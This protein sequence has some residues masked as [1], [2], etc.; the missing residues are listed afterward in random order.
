[1]NAFQP[2]PGG[3]FSD[4]FV[5]VLDPSGA[6][7]Y[8]TYLGGNG[9][10]TDWSQSLGP[11]VAVTSSG[12]TYVTG[13]TQSLNFPVSAD[14]FQPTHGG[15]QSDVFVTRFDTAGQLQYSTYLGGS[16]DDYGRSVAL[17][18]NGEVAVAGYTNSTDFPTRNAFQPIPGRLG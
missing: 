7:V 6:F 2:E 16:G 5:S 17:D 8:S 13:T 12:E 15:G 10:E 3:G 14:A 9:A 4:V 11:D 1:M 18:V